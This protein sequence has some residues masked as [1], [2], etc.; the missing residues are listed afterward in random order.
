MRLK[1]L[2]IFLW[3]GVNLDF[4]S[5]RTHIMEREEAERKTDGMNHKLSELVSKITTVTGV[6]ITGTAS[7][8]ELLTTKVNIKIK[9]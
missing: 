8:I 6:T 3:T 2:L 5:N 9:W 7:G 4:F 1:M